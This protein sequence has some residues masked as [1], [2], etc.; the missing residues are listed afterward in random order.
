MDKKVKSRRPIGWTALLN[1]GHVH[2]RSKTAARRDQRAQ[3]QNEADE[4]WETGRFEEPDCYD[5]PDH[6]R[7]D[8]TPSTSDGEPPIFLAAA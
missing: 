1:K 5:D 8:Y 6:S 7:M 2:T 3:L 4:Y